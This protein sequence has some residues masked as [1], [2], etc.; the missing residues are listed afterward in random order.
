MQIAS[1][2]VAMYGDSRKLKSEVIA[3][4]FEDVDAR[5]AFLVELVRMGHKPEAM[6]QS[7]IKKR[8]CA[9]P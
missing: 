4:F 6:T 3:N 2:T 5:V 7:T 9:L 8:L 1:R